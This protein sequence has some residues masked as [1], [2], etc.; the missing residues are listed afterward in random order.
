MIKINNPSN[1]AIEKH[2]I[3]YNSHIKT[4]LDKFILDSLGKR[5]YNLLLYL[6][7]NIEDIMIGDP[8]RLEEILEEIKKRHY[9]M[10]THLKTKKGYKLKEKF[11]KVFNY[12]GFCKNKNKINFRGEDCY[13]NAYTLIESLK[14]KTCPYCNASISHLFLGKE[15]KTRPTLDH[16]LDKGTMPYFA[17]SLFNLIPACYTCNS[18]FKKSKQ[19]SIGTHLHP[20]LNEMGE[21]FTFY[22]DI[23]VSRDGEINIEDLKQ[24][25]YSINFRYTST[26]D[27]HLRTKVEN[28]LRDF[29]ILE[30]YNQ[31]KTY[32][33]EIINQKIIYTQDRIK[34]L[35][36]LPMFKNEEDVRLALIGESGLY[37]YKTIN[38]EDRIFSKLIKDIT[39]EL[40]L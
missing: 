32:I 26:V 37:T 23:K 30:L 35:A 5:H 27:P 11:L 9:K 39:Q 28:S 36:S 10:Y 24:N 38:L 17:I 22:T 16:F 20:Y 14:V 29:H 1:D 21:D 12:D 7:A 19:F 40:K 25:K 2:L 4:N 15:G 31:Q 33:D 34:E 6:K 18:S 3:Y 13:W 8:D